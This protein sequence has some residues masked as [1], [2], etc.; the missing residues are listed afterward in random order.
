MKK[1][2]IITSV[3]V[4]A[5]VIV[6]T[7]V[8]LTNRNKEV[9]KLS[10]KDSTSITVIK[11]L[12]GKRVSITGYM[13]TQSP[14][15]GSYIYL[16]NLPYQAC[17]F[18][19]P[20]TTSLNNTL[21]VYAKSGASFTYTDGPV[22]LEGTLT[23]GNFKDEYG[24]TYR[25][26]LEDATCKPAD[27]DGL[28]QNIKMYSAIS[29]EGLV[30]EIMALYMHTDSNIYYEEYQQETSEIEPIDVKEIETCISK[31]SAISKTDYQDLIQSLTTLK[32][33]AEEVNANIVNGDFEANKNLKQEIETEF[34][35]IN[36]WINRYEV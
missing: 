15:D 14:L 19:L 27:V 25:Y 29:Q 6:I 30:Q 2:I 9:T 21:A 32:G 1:G 13:A 35:F 17:P 3:I 11:K 5:I 28:S 10:F 8:F 12:E 4:L 24:Y 31:L 23:M 36:E 33:I 26:R 22:T 16:M 18:C 20:N 34:N 7:V